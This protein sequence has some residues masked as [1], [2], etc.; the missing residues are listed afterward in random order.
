M[1]L[2]KNKKGMWLSLM[3]FLLLLIALIYTL[4]V[5][6]AD[7]KENLSSFRYIGERSIELLDI[8]AT[9]QINL[10]YY[11]SLGRIVFPKSL[12][13]LGEKGGFYEQN[14]CGQ[15][16]G[17][18]IWINDTKKCKPDYLNS[19]NLYFN[20]N[21]N[22]YGNNESFFINY[23]GYGNFVASAVKSNKISSDE[24]KYSYRPNFKFNSGYDFNIY[25]IAF[26]NAEEIYYSCRNKEDFS[27]CVKNKISFYSGKDNN[28]NW[29]LNCKS[30]EEIIFYT[31]IKQYEKCLNSVGNDCYCELKLN[32]FEDYVDDI[33]IKIK[34]ENNGN[35]SFNNLNYQFNKN[36]AKFGSYNS[37]SSYNEIFV[38]LKYENGELK[39]LGI[40]ENENL[41]FD[42]LSLTNTNNELYLY[43]SNKSQSSIEDFVLVTN[44][45]NLK[46][47]RTFTRHS[48]I[49]IEDKNKYLIYDFNYDRLEE[50]SISLQFS[51]YAP[52]VIPPNPINFYIEN[53]PEKNESLFI[54][55]NRSD[56][57][58]ISHYNIYV[59]EN[60]F[61]SVESIEPNLSISDFN[62]NGITKKREIKVEKDNVPYYITITPVDA[63]ENENKNINVIEIMSLPKE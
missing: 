40:T 35:I 11:D 34:I 33:E 8:Y 16:A 63:F 37:Y 6:Q 23:L 21:L 9:S 27:F 24:I 14:D 36:L 42:Q 30:N 62:L 32:N 56:A 52:D 31:F 45:N 58:D 55:F 4:A 20:D 3:S 25:N 19:L 53:N 29:N 48:T 18:E 15:F 28:F 26:E 17:F 10:T 44:K 60:Q 38:L 54:Y 2:N 43:K 50:K 7:Q 39:N 59:E 5:I 57:Y 41:N 46:K 13:Q 47:C 61:Y 12:N 51:I 22:K 1:K 49:C